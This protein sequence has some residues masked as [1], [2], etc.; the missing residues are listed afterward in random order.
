MI[1]LV[2]LSFALCC[3]S[4]SDNLSQDSR[5][6]TDNEDILFCR[7]GLDHSDPFHDYANTKCHG[8]WPLGTPLGTVAL[9]IFSYSISRK[10][11]GCSRRLFRYKNRKWNSLSNWSKTKPQRNVP[12]TSHCPSKKW[13][14]CLFQCKF[15]KILILSF[16]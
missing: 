7:C 8:K 13:C 11:K 12:Q 1:W 15:K 6:Q 10:S 9:N 16:F 3:S 2:F 14:T 5:N 4:L